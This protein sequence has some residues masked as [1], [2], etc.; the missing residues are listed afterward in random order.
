VSLARIALRGW[1]IVTLTAANVAQVAGG[2]YGGAFVGG[3]LISATWW[4]N[5]H[6][7]KASVPYGSLAYGSGAALGTITGM[8]LMR[9][10]YGA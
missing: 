3:F 8:A 9:W 1:W 5:S 10:F 6:S 2:H 4:S 7:A